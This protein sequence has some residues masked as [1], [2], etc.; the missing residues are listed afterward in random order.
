MVLR[1]RTT[2]MVGREREEQRETEE[3]PDCQETWERGDC[4][5]FGDLP[6]YLVPRGQWETRAVAVPLV[7]LVLKEYLVYMV[8]QQEEEQSTLAG[9]GPPV[10][11]TREQ[12]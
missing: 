9:G 1:V 2:A 3:T 12:H 7:L 8:Q 11:L 10:P 5:V 6:E 4:Q